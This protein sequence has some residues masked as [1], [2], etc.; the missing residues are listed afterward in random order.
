MNT[1]LKLGLLLGLGFVATSF[2]AKPLPEEIDVTE[3]IEAPT[4]TVIRVSCP[5]RRGAGKVPVQILVGQSYQ[6]IIKSVM[7][8]K[9]LQ[10]NYKLTKNT[11]TRL[12]GR[13]TQNHIQESI[14]NPHI[15]FRLEKV[16]D[17]YL[18][19]CYH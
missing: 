13:V 16:E 4:S 11:F 1:K 8:Q 2:G 12:T 19:D 5:G 15:D 6:N 18:Q 14:E 7:R 3:P 17:P 9:G 10:G